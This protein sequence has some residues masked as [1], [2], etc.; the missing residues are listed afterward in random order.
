MKIVM[1]SG[2]DLLLPD[3]KLAE[4]GVHVVPLV[5]TL[6]GRSYREG[7]DIQPDEFYGLLEATDGLPS[8]SQPSVGEFVETYRRLAVDDPEILS[9]HI[10]SGLS[11]TLNAAQ[12][13]AGLVPEAKVTF[14]DT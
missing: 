9:I 4:L 12:T 11:G 6:D 3:E 1:D 5:V 7:V 8:T 14:V 13:A 2:I 10:S